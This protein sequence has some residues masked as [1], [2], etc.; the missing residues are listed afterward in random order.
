MP[1]NLSIKNVPDDI[2][3]H[4]RNRAARNHRSL[5]GELMVILE[6]AAA[7]K[8]AMTPDELLQQVRRLG[9][10]TPSESSEIVRKDRDGR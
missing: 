8:T 7:G 9:L 10:Q 1:V 4:L 5:Q 3:E 6:D 2:A